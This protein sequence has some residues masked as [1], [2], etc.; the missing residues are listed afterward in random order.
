MFEE[1]EILQTDAP[2]LQIR[3]F[4]KDQSE[5]LTISEDYSNLPIYYLLDLA[6][7]RYLDWL[8]LKQEESA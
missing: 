2:V 6:K 1:F 3:V 7:A 5:I 8:H 4:F